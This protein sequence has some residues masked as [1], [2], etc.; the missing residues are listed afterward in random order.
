MGRHS[1]GESPDLSVKLL[2]ATP[3]CLI[4]RM[5]AV[6]MGIVTVHEPATCDLGT[7]TSSDVCELGPKLLDETLIVDGASN[8]PRGRYRDAAEQRAYNRVA[9]PLY[10]LV[11]AVFTA[12]STLIGVLQVR[13]L[14][15]RR[16][17]RRKR[18][19]M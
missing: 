17:I 5:F 3:L 12:G 16:Q 4:L 7:M 2:I 18:R 11:G 14:R 15:A 9:A 6:W 8:P 1:S 19:D 13:G 10:L